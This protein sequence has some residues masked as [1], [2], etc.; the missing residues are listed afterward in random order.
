MESIPINKM[1]PE[2]FVLMEDVSFSQNYIIVG[3][4]L[5]ITFHGYCDFVLALEFIVFK[6]IL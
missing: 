6:D 5:L 2:G 3:R 1:S 4:V